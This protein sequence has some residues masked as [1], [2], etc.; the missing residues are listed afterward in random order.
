[1]INFTL[2]VDKATE[3]CFLDFHNIIGSISANLKQ[4]LLMLFLSLKSAQSVSQNPSNFKG[5]CDF[6]SIRLNN[7]RHAWPSLNG[8]NLVLLGLEI[9]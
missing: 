7:V 1:M 3:F 5:F 2:H 4:N 6:F 9:T 8:K